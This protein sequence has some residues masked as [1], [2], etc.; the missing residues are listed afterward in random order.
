MAQGQMV[1]EDG[2]YYQI[3]LQYFCNNPGLD[4]LATAAIIDSWLSASW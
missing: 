2:L 3:S 4:T 1:E